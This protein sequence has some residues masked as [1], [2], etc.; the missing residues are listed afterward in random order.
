MGEEITSNNVEKDDSEVSG[1]A[2]II[3]ILSKRSKK[4]S[5]TRTKATEPKVKV[6]KLTQKEQQIL[7]I[8]QSIV[9]PDNYHLINTPELLDKLVNYYQTYKTMWAKDAFTFI[10]TET[11]GL[12]NWKDSIITFQIGF[13][14]DQHFFVP[15]RPFKHEMSKDIPHVPLELFIEKFKPL[16]EKDKLLVLANAKF[17]I[18][19]LFNWCG[20]DITWNIFWDTNVAGGLL[21]EN[22]A[23]GLKEWYNDYAV[24]DMVNKGIMSKDE[25]NRPT[26]K[27]GS[28]FDKIPFDEI[29][30]RLAWYYGAHDPFMTKAV[31]EY[32]KGIFEN[33]AFGLEKVY[34]LFREVEMPLIPVL[35][36]A[37]RKGVKLDANF[38]KETVGKELKDKIHKLV[39]GYKDKDGNHVKG[40]YDYLGGEITLTRSK[41]RQKKGIKYKEQYEV[42]EQFNL[43]S[44]P[45]MSAKLYDIHG[46]LQPVMEYDKDLKKEVPKR[47]TDRK[48]LTRNK[49]THPVIQLILE[50]RGLSK[51]VDA[52]CE[53]LPDNVVEGRVHCSY[54]QLVR[55]GRMSCSNPNLQQ[56]PSKFDLIRYAFRADE[57]RMLVS[58]DFSQQELRWL[59]IVTKDNT[60]IEIFNN[61]LDMHSRVT[62]QIH[63]LDYSMF[64]QIRGYKGDTADETEANIKKAIED[65]KYT[66]ELKY[67]VNYLNLKNNKHYDS[68]E[69][70]SDLIITLAD[71][72][73]LMRKKTKSV[74]TILPTI[75]LSHIG[76]TLAGNTEPK[77]L[78]A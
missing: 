45:Q 20:I 33:A 13:M 57:N 16:L 73:E 29:P 60:L 56:V 75:N 21:N 6:K 74:N 24:P 1:A 63:G 37:E 51:L 32:Q 40:I 71:F 2:E 69:L 76:E 58:I 70:S 23:K 55:T 53:S 8:E 14:S 31:F 47:K 36:R 9:M 67:A 78:V 61:G 19:V 4:T 77:P 7:D 22:H 50:W 48:T 46:I 64:E 42:V 68:D 35:V 52:F 39:H 25:M 17:D 11:Y 27:F 15:L 26:F 41:T 72:F 10:D 43:S 65:W 18:H 5:K 30:H 49:K 12:N 3:D 28:L 66:D 44:P 54:N 59:A 34:K 62:C 38:L